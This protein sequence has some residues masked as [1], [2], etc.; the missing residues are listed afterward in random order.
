MTRRGRIAGGGSHDESPSL[1]NL[2]LCLS[3]KPANHVALCR[4]ALGALLR[5]ARDRPVAAAGIAT[6]A[7]A[8]ATPDAAKAAGCGQGGLQPGL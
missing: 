7:V 8:S 2:S 4:R 3:I 1:L 5:H 6:A